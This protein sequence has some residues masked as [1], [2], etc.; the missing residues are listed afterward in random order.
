MA[1]EESPLC[2]V[3]YVLNMASESVLNPDALHRLNHQLINAFVTEAVKDATSLCAL[4]RLN[5]QLI[6][7]FVTEVVNHVLN[8]VSAFAS[9]QRG[10]AANT[11]A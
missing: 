6:N 5:H 2:L 11:K 3:I 9:F 7:A 1:A 10:N 4:H 8:W